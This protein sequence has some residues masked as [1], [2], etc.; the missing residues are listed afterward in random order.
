MKNNISSIIGLNEEKAPEIEVESTLWNNVSQFLFR[1]KVETFKVSIIIS[2]IEK[3]T[4]RFFFKQLIVQRVL[5]MMNRYIESYIFTPSRFYDKWVSLI[6][7]Y[8]YIYTHINFFSLQNQII[9]D[10][11]HEN[12][13]IFL[14]QIKESISDAVL[15]H[16]GTDESKRRI[17][18]GVAPQRL[19]FAVSSKDFF[20][21]KDKNH[22]IT[23]NV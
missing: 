1:L 22:T 23:F 16:F 13:A 5:T 12:V 3:Y 18:F 19:C 7:I 17:G 21:V 20:K 4:D 2:F 15:T 11:E 9:R 8:I 10:T 6:Y 14:S